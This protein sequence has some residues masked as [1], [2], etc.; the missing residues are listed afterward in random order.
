MI[1]ENKKNPHF[2][3]SQEVGRSAF[4]SLELIDHIELVALQ[5][6]LRWFGAS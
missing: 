2:R 1:K 6:V 5:N 3:A 4:G